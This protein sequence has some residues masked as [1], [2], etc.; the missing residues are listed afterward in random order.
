M[1]ESRQQWL[2]ALAR[3]PSLPQSRGSEYP[4][5]P[6]E[7]P[8]CRLFRSAGELSVPLDRGANL[9]DVAVF[10]L[11][12]VGDGGPDRSGRP[13]GPADRQ[14]QVV[15]PHGEE[16]LTKAISRFD[17]LGPDPDQVPAGW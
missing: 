9:V 4:A 12:H 3:Q 17:Q 11:Q 6:G 16:G 13:F 14:V 2:D 7:G 8:L 10:V 5:K 15:F 1:P